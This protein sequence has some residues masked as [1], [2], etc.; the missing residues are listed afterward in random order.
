MIRTRHRIGG[1]AEGE[2]LRSK[3]PLE[4]QL[5]R[6]MAADAA[7]AAEAIAKEAEA[8]AKA[9]AKAKANAANPFSLGTHPEHNPMNDALK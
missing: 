2:G 5:E 6:R 7:D 1:V 8:E 9:K 3:R 4:S